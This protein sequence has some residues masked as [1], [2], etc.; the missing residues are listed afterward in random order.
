MTS[1]ARRNAIE[2]NAIERNATQRNH[3]L[4]MEEA[5]NTGGLHAAFFPLFLAEQEDPPPPHPPPRRKGFY[6]PAAFLFM[7]RPCRTLNLTSHTFTWTHNSTLRDGRF[8]RPR[9]QRAVARLM[10]RR[11]T[12]PGH[13]P[14]RNATQRTHRNLCVRAAGTEPG[15]FLT[16]CTCG[17]SFFFLFLSASTCVCLPYLPGGGPWG[18]LTRAIKVYKCEAQLSIKLTGCPPHPR[19][20]ERPDPPARASRGSG[21][22]AALNWQP[23][24]AG[25][26][27]DGWKA[28]RERRLRS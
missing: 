24:A 9:F 27:V 15:L 12:G 19:P 8:L 17:F 2:R 1:F 10:L 14:D 28:G 11:C 21:G 3:V 18:S 26:R 16:S 22:Q 4:H 5:L 13:Q 7:D 6:R 23:L 20:P 25:W